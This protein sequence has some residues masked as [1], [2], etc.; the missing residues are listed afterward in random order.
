ME[1]FTVKNEFKLTDN[2][3]VLIHIPVGT[4]LQA[5]HIS[6]NWWE[7]TA[8]CFITKSGDKTVMLGDLQIK[9]LKGE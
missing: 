7:V 2:D 5:K 8:N 3:Q 6:G 9:Q 1:S 4:Q